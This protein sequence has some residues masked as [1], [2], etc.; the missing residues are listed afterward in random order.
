LFSGFV[1]AEARALD[2][3]LRLTLGTKLEDN[4][5][6]GFEFQPSLRAA[7]IPDETMSF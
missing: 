1:Q 3:R 2:E 6:S 4:D 7:F 5:S